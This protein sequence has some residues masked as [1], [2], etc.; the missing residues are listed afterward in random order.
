VQSSE[1]GS[2]EVQRA[3]SLKNFEAITI[4]AK[5]WHNGGAYKVEIVD[6]PLRGK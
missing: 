6:Y 4:G 5:L 2:T 1:A 3:K